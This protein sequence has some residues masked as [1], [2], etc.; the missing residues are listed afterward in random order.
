MPVQA[1]LRLFL[2]MLLVLLIF[3]VGQ[4]PFSAHAGHC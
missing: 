2:V 3:T 4:Q 1:P